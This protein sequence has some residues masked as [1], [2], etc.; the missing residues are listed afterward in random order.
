M[1]NYNLGC[2]LQKRGMFHEAVICY[3]ESI[4]LDPTHIESFYNL[5]SA[6]QELNDVEQAEKYYTLTLTRKSNHYYSLFNMGCLYQDNGLIDKSIE[7]F[8][9]GIINIYI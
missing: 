8:Q 5:G 3:Q 1:N 6:F 2:T 9:K 4:K 7:C